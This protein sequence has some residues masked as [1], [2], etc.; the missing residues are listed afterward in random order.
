MLESG[1]K[2]GNDNTAFYVK[3]NGLFLMCEFSKDCKYTSFTTLEKMARRILTF[4]KT[5]Y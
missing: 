4:Y 3:E 5:G 2:F 1:V